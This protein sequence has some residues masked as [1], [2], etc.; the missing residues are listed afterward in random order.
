[1]L[2]APFASS[3]GANRFLGD[4]DSTYMPA[5]GK[6][7]KELSQEIFQSKNDSKFDKNKGMRTDA[8]ALGRRRLNVTDDVKN[9]QLFTVP[10]PGVE[11][12]AK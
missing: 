7:E 2:T 5:F 1:M 6:G 9:K 11:G 10:E 3:W 8:A 4:K 12:A